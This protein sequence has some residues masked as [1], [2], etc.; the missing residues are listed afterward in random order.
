MKRKTTIM[1]SNGKAIKMF[2]G[3]PPKNRESSWHFHFEKLKT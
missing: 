3:P 1:K 2:L